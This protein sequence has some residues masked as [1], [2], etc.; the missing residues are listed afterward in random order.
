[1]NEYNIRN[2][3]FFCG[4]IIIL[5]SLQREQV[6]LSIRNPRLIKAMSYLPGMKRVNNDR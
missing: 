3:L 4:K 5:Y 6:Y 1:M 2:V